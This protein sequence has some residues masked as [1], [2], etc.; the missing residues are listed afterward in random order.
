MI[1]H[2]PAP[3]KE[4]TPLLIE[5]TEAALASMVNAAVKPDVALAVAVYVAPP[6]LAAPGAVE[7]NVTV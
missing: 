2:V 7:V 1:T 6:T 3:L 5:H 4:T